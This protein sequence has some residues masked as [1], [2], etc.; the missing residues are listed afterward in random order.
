MEK[1][2]WRDAQ[3]QESTEAAKMQPMNT[4]QTQNFYSQNLIKKKITLRI[5]LTKKKK[6]KNYSQNLTSIDWHTQS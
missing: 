6:K 2:C 4:R 3:L 5:W 1:D